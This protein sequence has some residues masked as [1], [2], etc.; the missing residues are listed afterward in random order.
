MKGHL[1]VL[2]Q[3]IKGQKGKHITLIYEGTSTVLVLSSYQI[4]KL[5]SVDNN[6][7]KLNLLTVNF[8]LDVTKGQN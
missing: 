4:S 8:V 6:S 7:K 1:L 5:H 2:I 3:L